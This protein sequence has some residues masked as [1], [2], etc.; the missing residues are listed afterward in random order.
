MRRV[1][2]FVI[3]TRFA[4]YLYYRKQSWIIIFVNRHTVVISSSCVKSGFVRYDQ[5]QN[6]GK[7]K[8]KS[9]TSK[10]SEIGSVVCNIWQDLYNLWIDPKPCNQKE[11]K[12]VHWS[13]AYL[14]THASYADDDFPSQEDMAIQNLRLELVPFSTTEKDRS[15]WYIFF[16]VVVAAFLFELLI[17][18]S[19]I[20]IGLPECLFYKDLKAYFKVYSVRKFA[21]WNSLSAITQ[22]SMASNL[23]H[24]S[25]CF[26]FAEWPLLPRFWSQS[27]V[28]IPLSSR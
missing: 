22:N 21:A 13:Y 24:L 26:S 28:P 11:F 18:F 27:N 6:I 20:K 25:L 7:T 14:T 3:C 9:R 12:H 8:K 5:K 17:F 23:L 10:W 4:R 15:N 1:Q 2:I 16:T 19:L